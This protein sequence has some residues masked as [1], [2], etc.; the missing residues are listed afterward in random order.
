MRRFFVSCILIFALAAAVF[1]ILKP[2]AASEVADMNPVAAPTATST[3]EQL[4]RDD[5]VVSIGGKTIRVMLADTPDERTRGLSGREALANDEGMLFVFPEDGVYG[6]WMKDMRF[7][8][9]ILWLS[10][11]GEVVHIEKNVSPETY[12]ASF[13]PLKP[14]RYV[15][16]LP[17]GF[18][19]AQ[20]VAT[21]SRVVL[22]R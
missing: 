15:L 19:E 7:S 21:G 1:F 12:P 8:I 11:L 6:F 13:Q 2:E 17:A 9:D 22:P 18:A 10:S 5:P 16:E 20:S 4:M 3:K 14:A